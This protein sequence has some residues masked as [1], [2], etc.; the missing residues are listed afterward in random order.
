MLNE[1]DY[2]KCGGFI[3]HDRVFLKTTLPIF[4]IRRN[5]VIVPINLSVF[6]SHVHQMLVEVCRYLNING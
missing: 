1:L 4:W 2:V 5:W 6:D 3:L